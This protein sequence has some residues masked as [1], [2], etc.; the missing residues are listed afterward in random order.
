MV[1]ALRAPTSASTRSVKLEGSTTGRRSR[2]AASASSRIS[3]VSP[4]IGSRAE[5]MIVSVPPSG[6]ARA[7]PTTRRAAAGVS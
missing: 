6:M 1:V 5:A 3:V 7:A 2:A 4:A